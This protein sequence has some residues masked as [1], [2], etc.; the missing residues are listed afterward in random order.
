M[1]KQNMEQAERFFDLQFHS[2]EPGAG[3]GSPP[4]VGNDTQV[5]QIAGDQ[6]TGQAVTPPSG[7]NQPANQGQS[8][9][10]QLQAA[11]KGMNE[12][13]R[14]RAAWLNVAKEYGFNSAEEAKQAFEIY[15]MIN[16][17]PLPLAKQYF[18]QNPDALAT[19]LRE[20][21]M[22]AA[23][24]FG[25]VFNGGQ[26]PNSDP[27]A[28]Y[29]G[30]DNIPE[31][32]KAIQTDTIN[33]VKEMLKQELG[34]TVRP[35]QQTLQAQKEAEIRSKAN[36]RIDEF[37][38]TYP[39]AG[40][41]KE[42]VWETVQKIGVPLTTIEAQPWLIDGIMMESIGG[43]DEF[44]KR[45]STQSVQQ[46]QQQVQSN[47]TSTAQLTPSGGIPAV[48]GNEPILDMNKLNR[49]A[50]ERLDAYINSQKT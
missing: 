12:A 48:E 6:T 21:P 32:V 2:D 8:L 30:I 15:K 50:H 23:Q 10:Q 31:L 40:I 27:Y 38:K 26:A 4:A 19:L 13:Q 35:I 11:I 14:E 17:D 22:Q 7:G 42:K 20:N 1:K 36:N 46:Y 9:E 34:Q 33:Q 24:L 45:I 47:A 49:I 41:T 18:S 5:T 37:I 16:Q 43:R 3:S 28:K 39:Q 44:I 29:E 25:Q